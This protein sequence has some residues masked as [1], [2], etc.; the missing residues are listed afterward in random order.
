M[1]LSSVTGGLLPQGVI[2]GERVRCGDQVGMLAARYRYGF[3]RWHAACG[4]APIDD[5]TDG[6]DVNGLALQGFDECFL[7]SA[8]PT[9]SRSWVA[10]AGWHADI[11][12]ALSDDPE[13]IPHITVLKGL[14][15]QL[16]EAERA[17]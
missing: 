13:P 10:G 16:D 12:M 11:L 1:G 9:A 6:A 8:A 7:E 4:A 2:G 15:D 17:V 3:G 5:L 14:D